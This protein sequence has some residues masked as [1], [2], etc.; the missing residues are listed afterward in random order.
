M[1]SPYGIGSDGLFFDPLETNHVESCGLIIDY[2][3]CMDIVVT[4]GKYSVAALN[5]CIELL[6]L[7][8]KLES[9]IINEQEIILHISD[10]NLYIRGHVWC[11]NLYD[12]NA[13]TNLLQLLE[14]R[15]G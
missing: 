2:K 11:R 12:Q 15:Q 7:N 4:A 8:V 1:Y 5:V 13:Y 3:S 10:P 14:Q 6:K 9:Y